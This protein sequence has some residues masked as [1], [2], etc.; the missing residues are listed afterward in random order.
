M[1][2]S[3]KPSVKDCRGGEAVAETKW[4]QWSVKARNPYEHENES[5]R[6]K[7]DPKGWDCR[8]RHGNDRLEGN[9]QIIYIPRNF[10][11][12]LSNSNSFDFKNPIFLAGVIV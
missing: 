6:G 5:A 4:R 11:Y 7:P 2:N 8:V 3:N 12:I 1:K 10:C 9:A